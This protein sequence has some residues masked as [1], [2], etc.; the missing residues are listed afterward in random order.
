MWVGANWLGSS[1]TEKELR[2]L[3]DSR[4]HMIQQCILVADCITG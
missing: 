3:A 2:G 1:F 4:L